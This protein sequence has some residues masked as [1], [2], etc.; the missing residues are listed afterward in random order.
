MFNRSKFYL[1][2]GL[3]IL[4]SSF[5]LFSLREVLIG[6]SYSS[7][8]LSI[9]S[10]AL[11][12]IML[13]KNKS[14]KIPRYL[15]F[16]LLFFVT[17]FLISTFFSR[18][19]GLSVWSFIRF[20][21]YF[22]LFVSIYNFVNKNGHAQ[23]VLLCGIV[24]VS[25]AVLLTNYFSF[26]VDG[27]LNSGKPFSGSFFWYNQMAGFLLF[28]IPML[29]NLFLNIK[30][31]F[32]KSIFFALTGFSVFLM[33]LT[34]SRA[35]WISLAISLLFF[36]LLSIREVKKTHVF[37]L[38]GLFAVL[39]SLVI[40]QPHLFKRAVDLPKELFSG[41]RTASSN[42]RLASW[43]AA[44]KM[45][46]DR[47]IMGVGPGTYGAVF[48]NYQKIPWIYSRNAH[49][50][51]LEIAAET[52]LPG[53]LSFISIIGF[54]TYLVIKER[55]TLFNQQKHPLL[56]GV[57]T[58]LVGTSF[59]SLFDVDW[60]RVTLFSL[61]WV[62]LAVFFANTSISV[63]EIKIKRLGIS[64]VLI[65]LLLAASSVYLLIAESSYSWAKSNFS[66][67]F[68]DESS[69]LVDRVVAMNPLDTRYL[70]LQGEIRYAQKTPTEAQKSFE[71][72]TLLYP[73]FPDS[74]FELGLM[75]YKTGDYPKAVDWISKSIDVNP[76]VNP[77]PHLTLAQA[78]LKLNEQDNAEKVLERAINDYFPLNSY[79][80]D[81]EYLYDAAGIKSQ[82]ADLYFQ[83]ADVRLEK[84]KEEDAKKIIEI[85]EKEFNPL[86]SQLRRYKEKVGMSP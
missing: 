15:S 53:A 49:N 42:L 83:L 6:T 85:V 11:L 23:K 45:V 54:A 19:I 18:E 62:F 60:S 27:D 72:I 40:F 5:F 46:D 55:K 47:P 76:Y 17:W 20:F 65:P 29:L 66:D 9:F 56:L 63:K 73:H 14:I 12:A 77:A 2:L 79:Y 78:Y 68:I 21:S 36:A 35:G 28:I 8:L 39:G 33:I 59:H 61:F 75:K 74:Y 57:T 24:I 3:I 81:F 48:R 25:L 31:M 16:V 43:N 13:L 51:F 71:K 44:L 38:V 7:I 26:V 64:L 84:G 50:Y 67:G 10:S 82:L 52:G 58:A 32:L 69:K 41:T 34:T 70:L 4:L 22:V 1:F 80:R 30:N 37:A 86:P